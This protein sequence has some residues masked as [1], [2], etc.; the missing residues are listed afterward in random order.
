MQRTNPFLRFVPP[1]ILA[2][3]LMAVYLNSMAPGL[4]WANFGVDG[5]DLIAAAATGGIAHP[6]GYPLYLLLAR[7]FQLI[8][9]GSLA[10]RTNLMSAIA[11]VS[12]AILVYGL[13]TRSFFHPKTHEYWMTGLASGIAF[14]LAP[15]IWSQAVIT[16][17]YALHSLFVA[18]ILYLSVF[19]QSERFTQKRMDCA[20]GLT[21]GLAM[22]NHLTT[23]LLLPV[24]LLTTI[25]RKPRLECGKY[26]INNW[27]VDGCSFLRRIFW[28]VIGSL[29]YLTLPLRAVFHP[30]VNWG[31][32]VTLDGFTWLVS[33]KLY[34]DL[35]LNLNFPSVLERIQ[36]V[37]ALLL[38]Q[39]G[40]IGLIVGL[41]GLIV[42]FKP[43]RLNFC[44]LWIMTVSSVFAIGYATTD[45]FMYLIPAFLC[46]AIWIGMGVGALMDVFSQRFHY[47]GPLVG[48]VLI[49]I[50]MIQAWGNRPQVDASH[51]LRAES[52]GKSVLSL[53]PA[54]ALVFAEG[55]EAIFALWYF[56]YALRNRPDLVIVATDLLGF[57]W[58]LQT[59]HTT[60][61]DLNIPGPFPFAETLV[62]ANPLRP[63]CHVQ[64]IQVSEINCLPRDSQLP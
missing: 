16:E 28:S 64:Y 47:I 23:V 15:L 5:G 48:M 9:I 4:T 17:V 30:P 53:A 1:G 33:G 26:W 51:D 41:T 60:Y 39:F 59:L 3:S 56:Q 21:F 37:A 7:V 63:I 12:A 55:D 8:P 10:F 13:A 46:F 11:A 6:T 45:A 36:S 24:V 52:F 42:F 2:V 54:H 31:N 34:Q 57:E 50:L 49:V 22:G 43:T 14:G 38:A 27:Q 20:L 58:Y 44:M 62:V 19:P 32:P 61:P 35:L 29:V 18:L 25:F 40:I